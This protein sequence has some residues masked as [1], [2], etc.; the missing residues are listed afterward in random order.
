MHFK[1]TN[2]YMK[3][4]SAVVVLHEQATNSLIL[5]K[6]SMSLR[7]HP[8]EICLPG[9]L[10]ELGDVDLWSTA[11]RELQEELGIEPNRIH[12]MQELS[13]E[14]TLLGSIIHPWLATVSTIKPYTINEGEVDEIISLPMHEV[15][16]ISNYKDVLIN[17]NGRSFE[18][19]QYMAS[20]HFVWGATARIMKQL[21][22]IR[23]TKA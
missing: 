20:E 1:Y 11:M 19:C 10:W 13:P 15:T 2:R 22:A 9:G 3:K 18:C 16:I 5:T 23:V 6:R 21:C 4:K 7:D 12:L 17:R 8:G 14:T